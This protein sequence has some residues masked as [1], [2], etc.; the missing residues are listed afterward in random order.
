GTARAVPARV[1]LPRQAERQAAVRGQG[2]GG[3]PRRNRAGPAGQ[4]RPVAGR[5][6]L[7][8]RHVRGG[9]LHPRCRQSGM[10]GPGRAPRPPGSITPNILVDRLADRM[11]EGRADRPLRKPTTSDSGY[12]LRVVDGTFTD[13]AAKAKEQNLAVFG[14]G[15]SGKTV[16][17]SSFYGAS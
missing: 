12:G 9:R 17:L 5:R 3:R 2:R 15:G 6:L 4:S 7:A 14:L 8:V 11:A 10:P 1:R 16:L 13:M